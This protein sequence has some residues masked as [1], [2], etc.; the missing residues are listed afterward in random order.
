MTLSRPLLWFGAC[1]GFF[2]CGWLGWVALAAPTDQTSPV[3]LSI[4]FAMLLVVPALVV[5]SILPHIS[6]PKSTLLAIVLAAFAMRL[7]LLGVDPFLSDDLYRCLWDGQVQRAGFDPYLAAPSDPALDDVASDAHWIEVRSQIN[8]PEVPTVYPPL[9]Q[10]L[11]RLAA[12]TESGW[13]LATLLLDMLVGAVIALAL[14]RRG[15]DPRCAILWWWHPLPMLECAIGGHPEI[16]AVFLTTVAIFWLATSRSLLAAA[17]L[18]AAIAAKLLPVGWVPLLVCAGGARVWIP[19]L[20]VLLVA[21]VPFLGSD[22]GL[23]TEGLREYGSSWYSGDLLYRPVGELLGLDPENRF[24]PGAQWLRGFLVLAW[25]AIAWHCRGLSPWRAFLVVSFAFALLSPTLHPWYLLWLLPA[26]VIER[27]WASLF[28]T[29]TILFQYLVLDNWRALGV[30]ELPHG[31]RVLV[32]G[33]P[34]LLVIRHWRYGRVERD[35]IPG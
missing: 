15:Q 11:F 18:G 4:F 6:A 29:W 19:L 30:W 35:T 32:F 3:F 16:A 34:L 23:A 7:L 17:A 21:L 8:H 14:S 10:L 27:S 28:L 5:V 26:A 33:L 20:V 13:R 9:S 1:T 24:S 31:T 12:H 25:L 22:L 2:I